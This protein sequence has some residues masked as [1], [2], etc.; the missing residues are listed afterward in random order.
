MESLLC[1]AERAYE[2][3]NLQ[4][5]GARDCILRR[6]IPVRGV[7]DLSKQRHLKSGSKEKRSSILSGLLLG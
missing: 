3:W 5:L 4:G 1:T 2:A 6:P 7:E